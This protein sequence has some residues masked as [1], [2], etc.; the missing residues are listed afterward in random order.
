MTIAEA[1]QEADA[2]LADAGIE[3]PHLDAEVLLADLLGCA[4]ADL[5]LAR[6]HGI[7]AERERRFAECV[8]RRTRREP[9]AQIV[10]TK[11]FWSLP[12]RVTPDVLTPRPETEHLVEATLT[13]CRS[14]HVSRVTCHEILDLCTGSGCI[15][16][17]LAHEL[18]DARF[19]VTD[20]SDEALAI[21]RE[22]LA[23][24]KDRVTFL[25][26]DLFCALSN[27]ESRITNHAFDIILSNPPYIPTQ[28][29]AALAPEVREYE[30]RAALDGGASGLDFIRRIVE[31]APRFLTRGGWLLLEIGIGQAE[32]VKAI[33]EKTKDYTAT[34]LTKDLAGIERVISLKRV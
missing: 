5:V 1:L 9:V 3:T 31:D 7:D 28:E 6:N 21:A 2:L 14:G 27:H 17:A 29:L 24:A 12:I 15:A 16:A 22:N 23:F 20:L 25:H 11:E 4:R 34:T 19:T 26:G 33:A 30:P 10:G 8:A 18:P 13:M 32:A